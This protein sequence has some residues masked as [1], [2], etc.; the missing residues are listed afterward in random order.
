M[1]RADASIDP[2]RTSSPSPSSRSFSVSV[3]RSAAVGLAGS[4]AVRTLCAIR[5]SRGR[6]RRPDHDQRG[7]EPLTRA[8]CCEAMCARFFRIACTTWLAFPSR[9]SVTGRRVCVLQPAVF[10][11]SDRT[12]VLYSACTAS[13]LHGVS[14]TAVHR[15]L[16]RDT[17]SARAFCRWPSWHGTACGRQET[18][19]P[20]SERSRHPYPWAG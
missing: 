4:I 10:L 16:T 6:E 14:G 8:L 11:N 7:L 19:R 17:D 9:L 18:N 13:T 12:H 15:H 1:A 3:T 2:D 20:S 5:T